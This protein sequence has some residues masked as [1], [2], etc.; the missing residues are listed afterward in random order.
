MGLIRMTRRWNA[1]CAIVL[2]KLAMKVRLLIVLVVTK[3]YFWMII[4][5][6]RPANWD[7]IKCFYSIFFI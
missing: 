6:W 3:A 1:N 2:V 4:N 7:V 5:A